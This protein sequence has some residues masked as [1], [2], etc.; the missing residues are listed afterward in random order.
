MAEEDDD[1]WIDAYSA[2]YDILWAVECAVTKRY[3][4]LRHDHRGSFDRDPSIIE[5]DEIFEQLLHQRSSLIVSIFHLKGPMRPSSLLMESL[6][7]TLVDWDEALDSF[8]SRQDS[9]MQ[10]RMSLPQEP[11]RLPNYRKQIEDLQPYFT[12]SWVGFI[13]WFSQRESCYSPYRDTNITHSL[14]Q[15]SVRNWAERMASPNTEMSLKRFEEYT[16]VY[17]VNCPK[18]HAVP[19]KYLSNQ[20]RWSDRFAYESCL[21]DSPIIKWKEGIRCPSCS[22]EEKIKTARLVEPLTQSSKRASQ[23][24]Y[25][26][27]QFSGDSLSSAIETTASTASRSV[28]DGGSMGVGMPGLCSMSATIP[29]TV[30]QPRSDPGATKSAECRP[31]Q[32]DSPISPLTYDLV[33]RRTY[34]H[35]S[36]SLDCPVSPLNESLN[37]PIP[38]TVGSRL[39]VDLPIPVNTPSRSGSTTGR[40]Q[41]SVSSDISSF[42]QNTLASA[43]QLSWSDTSLPKS[44]QSSRSTRFANSI[45]R[46]SIKEQHPHSTLPK[47]PQITFAA[48]GSSLLVW[49]KVGDSVARFDVS[50]GNTSILQG[51]VYEVKNIQ[52]VAAGTR[53]CAIISSKGAHTTVLTIFDGLSLSSESRI[54]SHVSG[55]PHDV[56]IA[57]SKDD[58]HVAISTHGRLDLYKLE[59]GIKQLSF[60][61]QMDVFELRGGASHKRSIPVLRTTSTDS[62]TDV[63]KAD[64]NSWFSTHTRGLSVREAAEEQL[65]QSA[66]VSRKLNFSTDSQRLV[67]ATQLGDHCVHVDV[68]DI[69]REPVSSL[70]ENSRSFKLPPWVLNDGDLT[71]V[72]Y[73]SARRAALVTACIGKEYPVLIPF[74]GFGELQNETFS[75]K[76][77]C[78]A[79]SPSGSTFV[80]ANAMTEII[81]FEY[82]AA[83]TLSPRKLK[84]A[85]KHIGNSVFKPGAIALA[86][87]AE[88]VLQVFWIKEGKCMLRSIRLGSAEAFKDVDIRA[89]YDRLTSLKDRRIIARAPSVHIPE[90][91]AGDFM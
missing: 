44:K 40:S 36:S 24:L 76:I 72:F 77:V 82:T 51:C 38:M 67:V 57:V 17:I 20:L 25:S 58:K 14:V 65:H 50:N 16:N 74:P 4:D 83:G 66:I 71:D 33:P 15:E 87:P 56:C 13:E 22:S 29:T 12:A 62:V 35:G 47:D 55:R 1:D 8:L 45:R 90:L 23:D 39:S 53:K 5:N 89:Q 41:P 11:T 34:S 86:M 80:V 46:K 21:E 10:H 43:S 81:Q 48:S 54:E 18:L 30:S 85:S 70:S 27:S 3:I 79:Q 26:Q 63:S 84:K 60:Q 75:T 91:D 42:R 31:P 49:D 69:T 37:I 7:I 88:D 73:D 59:D 68:W 6:A 9:L 61:H 28:S 78:A 19:K 64:P 52:A 2:I 32:Y